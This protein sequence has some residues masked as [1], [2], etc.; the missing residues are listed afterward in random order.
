M[1]VENND[2]IICL[3]ELGDIQLWQCKECNIVLHEHCIRRWG[4]N[5][6]HCKVSINN[7]SSQNTMNNS[8]SLRHRGHFVAR[9]SVIHSICSCSLILVLVFFSLV[10]CGFLINCFF[11][12]GYKPYN[13]TNVIYF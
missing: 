12:P 6:P 7:H 8:I 4:K 3:Q 10:G 9:E 5:C 2:C 1:D 11:I 13:R